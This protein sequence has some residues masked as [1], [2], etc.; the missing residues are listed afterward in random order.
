M[1]PQVYISTGAFKEKSLNSIISECIKHAITNIELSS[2]IEYDANILQYVEYGYNN[3]FKY[4]VHNYFPPAYP[5]FVLNLASEDNIVLRK[6][7]DHCKKAIDLCEL[8]SV[9]FFS[10]HCGFAFHASPTQLGRKLNEVPRFSFEKAEEI[11]VKSINELCSYSER[12]SISVL[13]E[14]NVLAM[15]NTIDGK[16]KLLLGVTAEE[17]LRL[18]E[19]ILY[20]N[21]GLLI[22]TGHLNVS[23][24]TLKFSREK[25]LDKVGDK[26]MVFHLNDNDGLSDS[27]LLF[28]SKTWFIPLIKEYR[29][30]TFVVES[31]RL[32]IE[33]ILSGIKIIKEAL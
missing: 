9:P 29:D 22:D 6:S 19:S 31:Y 13:V 18:S 33:Q 8:Y 7:I 14:N 28:N 23:A 3:N 17:L 1:Q 4:L 26:I 10:V 16:N 30:K 12:K 32:E 27:N 24:N 20:S 11:F 15:M 2:G 25:F 21:F 5:P